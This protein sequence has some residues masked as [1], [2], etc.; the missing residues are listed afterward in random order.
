MKR[1]EK[2]G[3]NGKIVKRTGASRLI[4][5]E[6]TLLAQNMSSTIRRQGLPGCHGHKRVSTLATIKIWMDSARLQTLHSPKLQKTLL[7]RES[8]L[9]SVMVASRLSRPLPQLGNPSC[10]PVISMCVV[11]LLIFFDTPFFSSQPSSPPLHPHFL[12]NR[13]HLVLE[14]G[15]GVPPQCRRRGMDP[16]RASG[17]GYE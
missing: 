7:S 15:A 11:R 12:S 5:H 1:E 2:K 16:V 17:S 10:S 13:E 4:S 9:S 6:D 3:T 8:G 14:T